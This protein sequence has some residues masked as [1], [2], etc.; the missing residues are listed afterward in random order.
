MATKFKIEDKVR[1]K[2][3]KHG[4]P[5][6][7]IAKILDY[8]SRDGYLLKG[9]A[10]FFKAG[11]L[12][13][14]SSSTTKFKKGDK[15]QIVI[16][17]EYEYQGKKKDGTLLEGEIT[18]I[19]SSRYL[20]Y[21]VKWSNGSADSYGNEH[22]QLYTPEKTLSTFKK[23][24]KVVPVGL[25]QIGYDRDGAYRGDYKLTWEREIAEVKGDMVRLDGDSNI[26]FKHE[27]W[28]LKEEKTVK[29]ETPSTDFPKYWYIVW[30]NEEIFKA[31]NKWSKKCWGYVKDAVLDSDDNYHTCASRVPSKYEEIT[32]EQFKKHAL[33]ETVKPKFEEGKIYYHEFKDG[34]SYIFKC[35]KT[36]DEIYSEKGRIDVKESS[37]SSGNYMNNIGASC[38]EATLKEQKWFRVCSSMDTFISMR[39]LD[40]FND[41]GTPN[42]SPS[43]IP[44]NW[45]LKITDENVEEVS[46]WR[47]AGDLGKGTEGW[48]SH[49]G[50]NDA[51]GYWT[52]DKP[53]GLKEITTEQFFKHVLN[54]TYPENPMYGK[55]THPGSSV[56]AHDVMD[57]FIGGIPTKVF[58]KWADEVKS[59]M[60]G[61]GVVYMGVGCEE[62][63]SN[64]YQVMEQQD[65][66]ILNRGTKKKKIFVI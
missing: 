35:S 7:T 37:F 23:G 51:R 46:K 6:G 11:E 22:L 28:K 58:D 57:T 10:G 12:E 59:R 55:L 33:K 30:K 2:F 9:W 54:K 62:T 61:N 45:C 4:I 65:A 19:S 16:G 18:K 31:V 36:G 3:S 66:I 64:K 52:S 29:E 39:E 40:K 14:E 34:M 8:N 44:S 48:I 20:P 43:K 63:S 53:R 5:K 17:C 24:D 41:D 32:F 56:S 25:K 27:S 60:K 26:W 50:Y 21:S 47:T 13:L 42:V 15:V 49:E 38:R 1:T